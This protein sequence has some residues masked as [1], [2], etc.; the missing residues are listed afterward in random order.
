MKNKQIILIVIALIFI[1]P[2]VMFIYNYFAEDPEKDVFL[3]NVENMQKDFQNIR[4]DI[5]GLHYIGK[6]NLKKNIEA[7]TIDKFKE[8]D[9]FLEKI[10][11]L[12]KKKMLAQLEKDIAELKKD[13]NNASSSPK[14]IS[15]EERNRIRKKNKVQASS[16]IKVSAINYVGKNAIVSSRGRIHTIHE[17]DKVDNF[18]V[19]KIAKDYI[20]VGAKGASD[21]KLYLNH[22]ISYRKPEKIW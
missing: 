15:A 21:Q 14:P 11:L 16:V 4:S 6:K 1:I 13:T 9:E 5:E 10:I 2:S 17:G 19:K 18:T 3:Q 22:D 7:E 20:L 8:D 12:K